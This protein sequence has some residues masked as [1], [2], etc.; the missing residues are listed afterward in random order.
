MSEEKGVWD[1]DFLAVL[2][3]EATC[4]KDSNAHEIIEFPTVVIDVRTRQIVDRIEQFVKPKNNPKL[5]SFC[6]N[7]TTITQ[8]QVDAGVTFPEALQAQSQLLSKYPNAV[9]VTCGDWDLKTMLPM[10]A[11]VH[12]IK[13]PAS[14]RA[15]IN[16]KLAF[17]AFLNKRVRGMEDMLNI[18]KLKLQGTPHRGIDDCVNIATICI[19]LLERGW[20]PKESMLSKLM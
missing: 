2:D 10:D 15:W 6:T 1:F 14:Y 7:L 5:S 18:L 17:N 8:D 9:L 13:I 4:W 16:I 20:S 12:N 19:A 3:F 11:K